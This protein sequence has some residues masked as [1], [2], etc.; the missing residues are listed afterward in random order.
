MQ[1]LGKSVDLCFSRFTSKTNCFEPKIMHGF[2]WP[3]TKSVSKRALEITVTYHQEG[4]SG[5]CIK[6]SQNMLRK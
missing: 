3:N 1:S 6:K 2:K 5:L 4:N